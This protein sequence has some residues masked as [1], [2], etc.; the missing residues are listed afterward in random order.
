MRGVWV[1]VR[2]RIQ[3]EHL[4]QIGKLFKVEKGSDYQ[5]LGYTLNF[6]TGSIHDQLDENTHHSE[7][8]V[9]V[10]TVLLS[11]YLLAKPAPKRDRLVK[12]KDLP[13]GYAYERAFLQRAVQPIAVTFGDKPA[14]LVEA[15]SL[16]KGKSISLGDSAVEIPVLEGIPLVYIVWA[17]GEFPATASVLF[18][19]SASSYL[20][21]EDLGIVAELTTSR[22]IKAKT[23][24]KNKI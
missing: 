4:E 18:D 2:L 12:Y 7:A 5:T 6:E 20:P 8:D 22:L 21:T 14:E 3:K 10:L 1:T 11:H 9:Q 24:I 19:E 23:A 15:A 13:G 17:K 16:L